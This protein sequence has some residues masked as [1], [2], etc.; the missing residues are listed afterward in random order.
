MVTLNLASLLF[1]LGA[2]AHLFYRAAF[3]HYTT[4][5]KTTLTHT[6]D[7]NTVH[8]IISW[9]LAPGSYVFSLPIPDVQHIERL[10]MPPSQGELAENWI[11]LR[12]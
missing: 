9:V 7:A 10:R 1:T 3:D 4:S 11:W 2:V 8:T 12:S 5:W 6:I